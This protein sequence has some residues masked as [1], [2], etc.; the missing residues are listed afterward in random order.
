MLEQITKWNS[1][2]LGAL[3]MCVLGGY[4]ATATLTNPVIVGIVVGALALVTVT[5]IVCQAAID[6]KHGRAG[7]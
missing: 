4:L 6:A 7:E 2:K 3:A 5:Y 1:R